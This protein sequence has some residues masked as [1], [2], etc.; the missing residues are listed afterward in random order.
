MANEKTFRVRTAQGRT[1]FCR[2]ATKGEARLQAAGRLRA[3]GVMRND[4]SWSSDW[5]VE[6]QGYEKVSS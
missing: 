5:V 1:M 6:I 4:P 2:A 3:Y